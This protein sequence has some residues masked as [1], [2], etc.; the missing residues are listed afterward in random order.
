[1]RNSFIYVADTYCFSDNSQLQSLY[2]LIQR[3]ES[4]LNQS[5][6]DYEVIIMDDC[7]TDNSAEIIEK[8]RNHPN[9][10]NIIYN[11]SNSGSTFHQWNKGVDVA[12][13]KYIWIAESDDIAEYT[14]LQN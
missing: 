14:F 10:A 2:Y 6:H 5:Y 8:Y 11:T 9:V 12:K 1:M 4:I 7:S 3:I 13:G